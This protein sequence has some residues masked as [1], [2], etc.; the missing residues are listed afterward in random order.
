M[1]CVIG[2]VLRNKGNASASPSPLSSSRFRRL[3]NR[4]SCLLNFTQNDDRSCLAVNQYRLSAFLYALMGRGL[5][6]LAPFRGASQ[7]RLWLRQ[8]DVTAPRQGCMPQP[9]VAQPFQSCGAPPPP[10]VSTRWNNR[11]FFEPQSLTW[12]APWNCTK[13]TGL[14]FLHRHP[15]PRVTFETVSPGLRLHLY[16]LQNQRQ[17]PLRS[18]ALSG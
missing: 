10:L 11:H 14:C 3:I 17:Y 1:P 8:C 13:G 18:F 6:H 4:P 5:R 9:L 15:C 7:T 2:A 16:R 12:D